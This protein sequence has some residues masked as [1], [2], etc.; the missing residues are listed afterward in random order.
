MHVFDERTDDNVVVSPQELL[1][2]P[3][4]CKD[5]KDRCTE[6]LGRCSWPDRLAPIS[7]RTD[8]DH[9]AFDFQRTGDGILRTDTDNGTMALALC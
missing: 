9:P 5:T 6:Y 2:T 3:N 1:A 8:H 7:V 4:V